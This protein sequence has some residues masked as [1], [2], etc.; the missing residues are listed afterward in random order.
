MSNQNNGQ[1]SEP[2]RAEVFSYTDL[3]SYQDGSIVSRTII[4]TP[5]GTVTVFAFDA[6]QRLSEHTAPF[7]ALIEIVDGTGI[8]AID[9]KVRSVPAGNQVIVPA[10]H[11][12]AVRGDG[13]FKMVLVMIR[14]EKTA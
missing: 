4:D 14:P 7:D 5:A 3:V 13:R 8:I 11:P 2:L 12:H 9:G 10:K 1:A 6:E